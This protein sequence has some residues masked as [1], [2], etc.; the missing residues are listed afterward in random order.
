MTRIDHETAQ[1][2]RRVLMLCRSRGIDPVIALDTAGL[3]R[4][5]DKRH[6][7]ILAGMELLILTVQQTP[8]QLLNHQDVPKTPLDLK[9]FILD[10]LESVKKGAADGKAAQ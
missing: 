10:L 7:D 3:L 2:I 8:V 6:E 4:Y 9:Q 5:E 1:K